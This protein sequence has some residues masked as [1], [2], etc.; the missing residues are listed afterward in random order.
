MISSFI[1]YLFKCTS[2]RENGMVLSFSLNS[3]NI[4]ILVLFLIFL[5]LNNSSDQKIIEVRKLMLEL[6]LSY[7]K[8]QLHHEL[9]AGNPKIK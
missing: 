3:T 9:R 5:T 2:L 4:L 7:H 8:A 1:F 6:Y